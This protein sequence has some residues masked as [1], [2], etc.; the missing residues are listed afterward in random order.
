[1]A[2]AIAP[3]LAACP[4]NNV[5]AGVHGVETMRQLLGKPLPRAD[6]EVRRMMG[7][8][9]M[10]APELIVTPMPRSQEA[11]RVGARAIQ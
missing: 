8:Q 11:V 10:R 5:V 6:V 9:V 1:M 4:G 2:A 3:S 7:P